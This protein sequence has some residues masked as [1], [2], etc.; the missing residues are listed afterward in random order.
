MRI[1]ICICILLGG[2][3]VAL[4]G[5]PRSFQRLDKPQWNAMELRDGLAFDH[6]WNAVFDVLINDFDIVVVSKENGYIRTD[7]LYSY[8]GAYQFGYR[9]RVTVRFSPDQKTVRVKTEAQAMDG[10]NWIIGID[11]RLISTLKTDL[12]GRSDAPLVEREKE[13]QQGTR[14]TRKLFRA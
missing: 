2:F 1:L 9:V 13:N 8:G 7:W 4:A 14:V 11:S 6:A 10:N 12:M 5:P 3:S